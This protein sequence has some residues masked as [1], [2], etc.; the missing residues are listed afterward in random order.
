MKRCIPRKA[1]PK[2]QNPAPMVIA[3]S[4]GNS[5][6]R[7]KARRASWIATRNANRAMENRLRDLTRQPLLARDR[8]TVRRPWTAESWE[9]RGWR[10]R[11]WPGLL[12]NLA[13]SEF[14]ANSAARGGS[15][16]VN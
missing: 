15:D 11:R 14:A 8:S 9:P 6:V 2:A 7:A 12:R 4:F 10:H 16:R 3:H 5:A 1:R 13:K